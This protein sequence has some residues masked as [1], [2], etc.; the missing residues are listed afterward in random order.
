VDLSY[1]H[2]QGNLEDFKKLLV[3]SFQNVICFVVPISC[4][5]VFLSREII[6]IL[7]M[8][9][10]FNLY[11]LNVT[12]L[13]LLFYAIGLFFFCAIKVFVNAFY[14]LKDNITPAK[15]SAVSLLVNAGLSALLMFPLR[16][17]GVALGSSLA[18]I[19]NCVLLYRSLISKIG[20]I[21]WEDTKSQFIKVFFLSVVMGG[22]ARLF[23]DSMVANKYLKMAGAVS[24]ALVVFI[25]GGRVL[26][27]KQINYIKEHLFKKK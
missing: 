26:G 6:E 21:D 13:A 11:S 7:F 25:A 24:I 2:K 1:Y 14:S 20:K 19:F 17:G 22:L 9:G 3:F 16:I 8:R 27:L 4:F 10:D 15:T 18:A 23:W 12:S 5:Y